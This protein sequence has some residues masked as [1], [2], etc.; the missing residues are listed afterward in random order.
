VCALAILAAI[1]ATGCSKCGGGDQSTTGASP[2]AS[3]PPAAAASAVQV[4]PEFPEVKDTGRGRAT[5][6]LRSILGVHGI[7]FDAA[8]LERECKVD[9]D[10]ASIDD[11]EDVAVKY[12]LDAAQIVVPVEHVLLPEAKLLPA[13]V[14]VEGAEENDEFVLAWRLDGERAYVMDPVEGRRAVDR[15]ELTDSLSIVEVSIPA[16]KARSVLDSQLSQDALRARMVALGVPRDAADARLA[17]ALGDPGWNGLAALDAA[18]RVLDG[19][20]ARPVPDAAA[21][22]DHA[23]DCAL[24]KRCEGADPLPGELWTLQPGEKSGEVL[25]RGAV[26]VTIPGRRAP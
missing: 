6:A 7:A 19:D 11:I 16:E 12:G 13:I 8:T 9:D 18:I 17:K 23:L 26:L 1:A 22:L 2:S 15:N 14:I 4:P 21:R 24:Q 25:L 5:A 20:P 10:G 3:A